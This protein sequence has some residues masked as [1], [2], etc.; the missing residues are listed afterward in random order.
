[1]ALQSFRDFLPPTIK[2]AWLNSVDVL[3]STIFE[4][5][6]T[7]AAARLALFE[8]NQLRIVDGGTGVD[9]LPL[10]LASMFPSVWSLINPRTPLEIAAGIFPVDYSWRTGCVDRYCVN[11]IPGTTDMS[12][13]V[14]AAIN[15]ALFALGSGQAGVPIR[16][17]YGA[18]SIATPLTFGVSTQNIL[19]LDISGVGVG[20]QLINNCAANTS[21]LLPMSGKCGYYLHDFSMWNNSAHKNT[22]IQV[23]VIGGPL[24]IEWRIERIMSFM[25]GVGFYLADTNTGTIKDCSH[26]P[27]NP[28][29]AIVPQ[30][31]TGAD[32]G[33]GILMTGG[34]VHNVR[35]TSPNISPHSGLNA[36][37]RGIKMD[38]AASYGV[39]ID[40]VPLAQT[41]S[42]LFNEIA[43]DIQPTGAAGE[44][45][46]K[47]I[48][49]EGAAIRLKNVICSEIGPIT[50]GT[51]GGA[52]ILQAGTSNNVITAVRAG[53]VDVL[54][55]SGSN[56]GNTFIG[57]PTPTGAYPWD[58]ATPYIVGNY[59]SRLGV[60]Y[61][62]VLAHTN[63]Q[64]PNATYWTVCNLYNDAN[65][66]NNQSFQPN[67]L[68]NSFG[69]A[70]SGG[71]WRKLIAY[72]ASIVPAA[73]GPS[74]SVIRVTNNTLFNITSPTW[75]GASI[76]KRNGNP[77]EFTIRNESGGAMHA[78]PTF[79]GAAIPGW[80]SPANTFNRS[81]CIY[82][83]SDFASWKFKWI[84]LV[85]MPN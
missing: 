63:Q 4:D 27:G 49:H 78:A 73:N 15:L 11:A 26:W 44:M 52:L 79:A 82:Y 21:A 74:H 69:V 6:A 58:A 34:F 24:S 68:I 2:A 67:R 81:F 19:P 42:G 38:C 30:T 35:I 50:N 16:F 51:I 12:P 70:D 17:S 18:Y 76:D 71:S 48:Y 25:A 36:A 47:N 57:C 7:K 59:A 10:F 64:P 32:V 80:T 39:A 43:L 60:Q 85:D 22:G 33:V 31:V 53:I 66:G 37:I 83:D 62:C 28:P 54:D 77:L 8:A 14:Q 5:A 3:K 13:G 40:G 72:T 1:M 75:T 45:S 56:A 61:R 41:L 46:I 55:N 9:T 65:E 84:G 20:S 23:N 29:T